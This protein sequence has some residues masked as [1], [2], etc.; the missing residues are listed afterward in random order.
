MTQQATA[1]SQ[2]S[3]AGAAAT[4]A[5]DGAAG[6]ALASPWRRLVAFG[7]D[8]LILTLVTGALWGRLLA[9]FANRMSAATSIDPGDPAAHGAV[10]RVFGHTV[11][12][13]LIVLAPTIILAILYYWLLTGYWGTTIGKRLAGIWVVSAGDLAPVSLRTSLLRALIFVAGGEV[14][15]LFFIA[16]N[17]WLL[18]DRRRQALHDKAAKTLVVR[19]TAQGAGRP[20]L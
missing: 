5:A 9:S 11:G 12:P 19:R 10:G 18:A 17:G 16:D 15:P 7:I 13:Y 14:L 8:A 6:I 3:A 1:I 2:V 4:N 20:D